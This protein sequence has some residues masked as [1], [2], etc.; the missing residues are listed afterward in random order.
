MRKRKDGRYCLRET[1]TINGIKKI[2]YFYGDTEKECKA[3]RDALIRSDSPEQVTLGDMYEQWKRTEELRISYSEFKQKCGRIEYFDCLFNTKLVDITPKSIALLINKLAV[4][5][6]KTGQLTAKRTLTR[7]IQSLSNVFEFAEANRL[8]TYNPCKYVQPPNKAPQEERDAIT[9]EQYEFILASEDERFLPAKIIILTGMRRGELACLTWKD[10]DFDKNRIHITKSYDY[11]NDSIKPPKSKSGNRYI[12]IPKRLKS[13]LEPISR[14]NGYVINDNGKMLT[15]GQW[16]ALN[17]YLRK[18]C[19]FHFS[20]HQL[21]H[22]YATI[23]YDLNVD[24]LTAQKYLGH[25]S[26]RITM[27]IYTHLSDAKETISASA[28]DNF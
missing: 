12:P 2:Y 23:L 11:H 21:R 6:P 4:S 28:L 22:T 25:S 16:S 14:A 5:N 10:V 3:K 24:V 20:W 13:L 9:K 19:G 15:G 1:L 8:T 18:Q 26:P 7:Y 27:E 17:K